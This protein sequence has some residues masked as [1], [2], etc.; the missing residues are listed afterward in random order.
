[1]S[2]S[3]KIIAALGVVAGLGVAALPMAAF[4]DQTGDPA[5]ERVAGD[6]DIY[7]EVQDAI[8]MTITG[9]NDA[10]T[11]YGTPADPEADPAIESDNA[12]VKVKSPS[13]A[14]KIGN[15]V[16]TDFTYYTPSASIK[17]SSSYASLL[18]NSVVEGV[19]ND[20]TSD[21]LFGSTIT[22]YT[23]ATDGYTLTMKDKDTSAALVQQGTFVAPA[24]ADTIEPIG[25]SEATTGATT[26]TAGQGEWGYRVVASA[27]ATAGNW[28]AVP[29]ST[30]SAAAINSSAEATTGGD[31]TYVQYGV[32][33][34]ADQKTGIY[35]DTIVYTATTNNS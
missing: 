7:A 10:N 32:A 13:G 6:V 20:G 11:Y 21:T 25:S 30:G 18:P 3:T 24:T 29:V 34:K 4:A 27:S 1:M 28:L 14:N 8:A 26:L 2:K 23:N 16:L 12:Q 9:N 22:V 17:A 33:T 19:W 15:T 35:K 31:I 5:V